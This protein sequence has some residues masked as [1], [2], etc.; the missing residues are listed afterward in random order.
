MY[1][2]DNR[3]YAAA[4]ADAEAFFARRLEERLERGAAEAAKGFDQIIELGQSMADYILPIKPEGD[5]RPF[6]LDRQGL[7]LE[8]V[9]PENTTQSLRR[10]IIRHAAYQLG[11]R[12]APEG[13]SAFASLV[14]DYASGSSWQR[15]VAVDLLNTHAEH[16]EH[17]PFL[18]RIAGGDVR[19]VLSANYAPWESWRVVQAFVTA[20]KK[21]GA[22]VSSAQASTTRIYAEVMLP[23]VFTLQGVDPDSRD[24]V[25]LGLTY[26]TSDFG[27]G[28]ETVSFFIERLWC[29]NRAISRNEIRNIHLGR[30]L[31]GTELSKSVRLSPAT[32]NK[33]TQANASIVQDVVANVLSTSKVESVLNQ[34]GAAMNR[35]TIEDLDAETA[36]LVDANRMTNA[37]ADELKSLLMKNRPED[38][39]RG[40]LSDWKFSQAISA[41]ARLKTDREARDEME[42]LAGSYVFN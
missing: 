42:R 33:I 38:V 39:P 37:D 2:H 40:P 24:A 10:P 36:K 23:R 7:A 16:V 3:D 19:G 14:R 20:G 27:D 12:L 6:V 26:R 30:R 13:R 9:D 32:Y 8:F 25:C 29:T 34:V 5:R 1:H 22:V 31:S 11:Q 4:V 15:E 35:Q 41:L 18:V 28:A 17:G 21:L